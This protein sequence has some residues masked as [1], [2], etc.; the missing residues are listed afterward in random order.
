MSKRRLVIS[1]VLAVQSQSEVA[2]AYGVSQGWISRLMA[3]YRLEGEACS[4]RCHV[5][6]PPVP[7]RPLGTDWEILTWLD[8]CSRYAHSVTAHARVTGP[9][10]AGDVPHSCC[11]LWRSG[12][13][14]D[15]QR[16]GVHHPVPARSSVSSRP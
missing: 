3:R 14:P 1:A 16:A 9:D 12:F 4:S 10:R 13:H 5:L 6:L 2:R 7:D 8:D 15:R 11:R